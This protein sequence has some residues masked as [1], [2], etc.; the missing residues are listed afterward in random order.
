[1]DKILAKLKAIHCSL[2]K[3]LEYTNEIG[4]IMPSF[5]ETEEGE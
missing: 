1:V 3:I 4:L 2:E 5:I